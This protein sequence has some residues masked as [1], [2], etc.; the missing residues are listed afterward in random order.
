[1]QE[2]RACSNRRR[3]YLDDIERIVI[4]GLR[5]ELGTREAVSYFLHCYTEERRRVPFGI[6]ARR[7]QIEAEIADL[8]R[9]IDRAVAA[10]IQGRITEVEA[11]AHLP[12]LRKRRSELASELA[13]AAAPLKLIK[14]Q[15]ALIDAYLRDLER[16]ETVINSDLAEGDQT[17]AC[18]VRK[19]IE[20][21]TIM[22]TPAGSVPGIIVRGEL[23][24][25]LNFD[26][27]SVGG[28]GGAG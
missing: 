13:S 2:A 21:V 16:L 17:A 28:A 8:E 1:M 22:P 27:L 25:L 24:S 10:I 19:M 11:S 6:A 26:A 5:K 12:A 23:G 18:A 7:G 9:Q 20:T 4:D 3:Y 15:P 14:L